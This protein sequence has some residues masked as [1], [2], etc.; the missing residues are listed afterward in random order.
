MTEKR[1]TAC[2]RRAADTA[3][4]VGEFADAATRMAGKI[5]NLN[6]EAL[7]YGCTEDLA[8]RLRAENCWR[9]LNVLRKGKFHTD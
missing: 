5:A 2:R 1:R 3:N 6:F 4:A 9:A 7:K 8:S